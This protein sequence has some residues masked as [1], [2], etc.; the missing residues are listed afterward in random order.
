MIWVLSF[1]ITV[2][3]KSFFL[4]FN[5]LNGAEENVGDLWGI[6]MKSGQLLYNKS[7]KAMLTL[8][9]L[10]KKTKKWISFVGLSPDCFCIGQIYTVNNT[11]QDKNVFYD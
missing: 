10:L 3:Q 2:A 8:A 4:S 6:Y 9:V 1:R 11:W 5:F 7:N